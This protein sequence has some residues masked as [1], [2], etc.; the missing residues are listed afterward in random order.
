MGY[1]AARGRFGRARQYRLLTGN[2]NDQP[3]ADRL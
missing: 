2:N 3:I 1:V